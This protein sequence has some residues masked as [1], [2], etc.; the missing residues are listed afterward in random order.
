MLD[1]T[2]RGLF[3]KDKLLGSDRRRLWEMETFVCVPF[4]S[5][6]CV[7]S[8]FLSLFRFIYIYNFFCLNHENGMGYND[9]WLEAYVTKK[10]E[11]GCRLQAAKYEKKNLDGYMIET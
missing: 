8:F 6:V 2:R 9:V 10:I 4:F 7:G 3:G 1:G 11:I 5:E